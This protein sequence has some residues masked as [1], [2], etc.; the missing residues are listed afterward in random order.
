MNMAVLHMY[1]LTI[2]IS[3]YCTM[4]LGQ[5]VL[6]EYVSNYFIFQFVLS[7]GGQMAE[8]VLSIQTLIN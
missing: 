3:K 2:N 8:S 5:C 1:K 6:K 4:Y 7:L